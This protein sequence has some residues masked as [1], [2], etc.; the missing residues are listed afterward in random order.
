MAGK[1][2]SIDIINKR[3]LAITEIQQDYRDKGEKLITNLLIEELDER[4]FKSLSRSTVERDLIEVAKGN[5]FVKNLSE[6][7]YSQM[8]EDL[9]V[10]LSITE[11]ML[12]KWLDNPPKITKQRIEQTRIQR[13]VTK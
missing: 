13:Q 9:F 5:N 4:G 7:T 10:S 12:W 2:S 3:R 8:I 1:K 6:A 11:D